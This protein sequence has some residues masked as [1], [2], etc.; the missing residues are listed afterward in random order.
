MDWTEDHT[1]H[2]ISLHQ[3]LIQSKALTLFDPMKAKRGE[4]AVEEKSEASRGGEP[5][6]PHDLLH[7]GVRLTAAVWKQTRGDAGACLDLP[8][9][10]HLVTTLPHTLSNPNKVAS[11]HSTALTLFLPVNTSCKNP[12]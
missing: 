7:C 10:A 8:P 3:S 1:S 9:S 11:P 4:E 2:N 12:I 5:K 6:S